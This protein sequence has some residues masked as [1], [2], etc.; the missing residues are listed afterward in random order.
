MNVY[1]YRMCAYHVNRQQQHRTSGLF[2][3]RN[4][5]LLT[6]SIQEDILLFGRKADALLPRAWQLHKAR[7]LKMA[8][9]LQAS[10]NF[11]KS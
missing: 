6:L 4:Q 2:N 9:L 7:N 8:G 1:R 11:S 10:A 5:N 3:D